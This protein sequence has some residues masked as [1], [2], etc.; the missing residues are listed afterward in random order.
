MDQL[1]SYRFCK[2][3]RTNKSNAKNLKSLFVIFIYIYVKFDFKDEILE[4]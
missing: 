4:D 3:K 1:E 2:R